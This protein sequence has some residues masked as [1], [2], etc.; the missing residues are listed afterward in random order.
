MIIIKDNMIESTTCNDLINLF[1]INEKKSETWRDTFTLN[2][3]ETDNNF[4]QK[5]YYFY[6]SFLNSKGLSLYPECAQIVK[7]PTNSFQD[8]HLD[9]GRETTV[10]TSITYLNDNFEGGNT[11]LEEDFS[12]KPKTGRGFFL[13]GKKYKHGVSKINSGIRYTLAIWYTNNLNYSI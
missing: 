10:Y 6:S 9:S 8:L 3:H 11:Y 5:I 4:A 2:L 13:D 12:L 7:W 1:Q